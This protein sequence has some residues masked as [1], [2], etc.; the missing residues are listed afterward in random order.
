MF[1][2]E[3]ADVNNVGAA[4]IE[5]G[6]EANSMNS[7]AVDFNDEINAG[8]G[9]KDEGVSATDTVVTDADCEKKKVWSMIPFGLF[10]GIGPEVWELTIV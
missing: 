9:V 2:M 7:L 5:E 8:A 3:E 6:L 1:F 4:D 10:E